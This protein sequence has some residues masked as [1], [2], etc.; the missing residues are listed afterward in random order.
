[1]TEER[2]RELAKVVGHEGEDAK[3]AVRN[4][5]RDALHQV[6]ELIKDKQISEDEERRAEEEI[7]KYTDK[8]VRDIDVVVKAKED[9]LMSM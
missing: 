3:V 5:R 4:V 9:E 1:L 2:R 6:K 7:Q 8:F